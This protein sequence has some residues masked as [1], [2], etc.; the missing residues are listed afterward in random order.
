MGARQTAWG[1]HAQ[2]AAELR[3]RIA[4]GDY[5]AGDLLPSEAA[6]AYEFRV[7]RNTV[8]R[9]LATVEAE[10]LLD[11]LAGTGRVVRAPGQLR[12]A[13]PRYRQIAAELRARIEGGDLRPGDLLPSEA[14]LIEHHG[15]SRGTARQALAD[16]EAAGLVESRHG[17]G[18]IVRQ[19]R[20]EAGR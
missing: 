14:A 7:A 3:A 17:K 1:A 20:P 2:I 9:A 6:L 15:V 13:V 12:E 8:R 10:G 19:P 5:P 11:V 4:R 16:L 18:R